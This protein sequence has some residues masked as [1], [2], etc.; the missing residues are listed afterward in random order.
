[1]TWRLDGVRVY[2]EDDS[3][4][5]STP[6]KGTIELLDTNY[7]ILQTAGRA[8]YRR[9]LQFVVFSGYAESILPMAALDSVT[10]E[11]DD[12][13]ET[14]ISVMSLNPTR[15]YDYHDRLVHRVKAELMVVE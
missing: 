8:S 11:D 6:R 7:S 2:V 15:L 13:I 1:M 12:G 10:L 14:L 4:W 9:D 3:G 5:K